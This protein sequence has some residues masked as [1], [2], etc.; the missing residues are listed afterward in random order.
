MMRGFMP[1]P[2]RLVKKLSY[3]F[4]NGIIIAEGRGCFRFVSGNG[5]K[6][7]TFILNKM[8]RKNKLVLNLSF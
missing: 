3:S 1:P 8:K 7:D 6:Y 2:Q 5:I 4:R